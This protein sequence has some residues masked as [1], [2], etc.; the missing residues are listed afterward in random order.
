MSDD[1][2][3]VLLSMLEGSRGRPATRVAAIHS[4][5]R[6]ADARAIEP[7]LGLIEDTVDPFRIPVVTAALEVLPLFASALPPALDAI[8]RAH[9]DPRRRYVPRLLMASV[10]ADA[11]PRLLLLLRDGDDE[12]VMNA[13]TS[14]GTLRE[15]LQA[16]VLRALVEDISRATLVRGVAAS[17]LGMSGDPAAYDCLASLL[18]SREKSLV[19]GAID[20]LAELGDPRALSVIQALLASGRLD[21]AVERGARLALISLRGRAVGL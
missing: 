12:V 3:P 20:G 6:L 21:E 15:P 5:G 2:V 11:I 14:L 1:D 7:L 4:L 19:A 8:L 9:D 16:P 10:G 17:A 13:A 18:G